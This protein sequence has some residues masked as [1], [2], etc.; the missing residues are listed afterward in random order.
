[1][2]TNGIYLIVLTDFKVIFDK[3]VSDGNFS[4]TAT[5]PAII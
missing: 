1:M 4:T 3:Y 2:S 5:D